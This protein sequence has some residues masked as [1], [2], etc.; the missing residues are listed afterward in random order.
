MTVEKII[1]ILNRIDADA[2]RLTEKS[3]ESAELFFVKKQLDTRRAKDTKKYNVTVYRD[4]ETEE[5]KL[6]GCTDTEILPSDSAETAEKKLK[7][8]Y[9]AAQFAMNPYYDLPDAVKEPKK[10]KKG[11]LAEDALAVS[12]GKMAKALF[13]PDD[14]S[15]A[16]INSAEIFINRFNVRIVTSAGTDVSY[17]DAEAKGEFVVQCKTPED[18][19]MYF[20]FTYGECD[21]EALKKLV[22]EALD[23]VTD[24]AKAQ[25]TLKSGKYDLILCGNETAEVLSYYAARSSA[26]M[27][28]SGYSS[29]QI[30]DDIQCGENGEVCG[31]KLGL[32]LCATVPY[33]GEGIPMNDLPLIKEGKLEAVHGPNQFCRYLGIRPTGYYEKFRCE[34]KGGESFA[35]MKKNPCLVAVAFSDFQLDE[36]SGHF[37]GEIRLAYLIDGGKVTPVTGGSV[38]GSLIESQSDIAFSTDRYVSA[39]YEG[40]YAMKMKG[41]SVA[42]TEE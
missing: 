14:R 29:W 17:T 10:E 23:Y 31:E 1:E 9:Y 11:P 39:D 13:E 38:N 42:G 20:D 24:R 27:I 12:A 7:D 41:I 16:F 19:E 28:Y 5:R 37:G 40:P 33:S 21:T 4:A 8:A 3:E 2:W 26:Q 25:K 32:T 30:G 35:E 34:N 22:S 15:G 18:V 36:L 6:R